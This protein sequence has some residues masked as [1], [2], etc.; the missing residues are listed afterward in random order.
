MSGSPEKPIEPKRKRGRPPKNNKL[1]DAFPT[2]TLQFHTL[3]DASSP[4]A[5][6]NSNM[7]VKMGEPDTF[8]PL[9]KVS[10]LLQRRKRRKS[11]V[12]LTSSNESPKKLSG[13]ALLT[14]MSV[15]SHTGRNIH[16]HTKA[17]ENLSYITGTD[18]GGFPTP[19]HSTAKPSFLPRQI[20]PL[21]ETS[22]AKSSGHSNGGSLGAISEAPGLVTYINDGLF[23]FK[24]VV[25]AL[26]RAALSSTEG[27]EE[28]KKA[29]NSVPTPGEDQRL[30]LE[31]NPPK[32]TKR[33]EQKYP[34]PKITIGE[35]QIVPQTPKSETFATG[36]TPMYMNTETSEY[37]LTPQFN[38]MMYSM[39]N[40]NSPQQKRNIQQPFLSHPD[41]PVRTAPA[42]ISMHELLAPQTDSSDDG[43]ARAALKKV[44][45][46]GRE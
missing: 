30:Y 38:A 27:A 23:L 42:T 41:L 35:D 17:L 33:A 45:Q 46:R 31:P 16:V 19:P 13:S 20:V 18:L 22:S 15:S 32:E 6:S 3:L 5:E 12:V 37:N 11:S 2:L 10:P 14:P 1:A 25:D 9:M 36:Y 21:T 43:D 7:M 44:F 34:D 29:I 4:S 40:I 24:L 26:G 28:D 39:M 8:T